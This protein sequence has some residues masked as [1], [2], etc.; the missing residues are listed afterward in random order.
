[1]RST[2]TPRIGE[3]LLALV[4]EA[5]HHDIPALNQLES[6]IKEKVYAL[7]IPDKVFDHFSIC[8]GRQ[9]M[10]RRFV[11]F[12]AGYTEQTRRLAKVRH[13]ALF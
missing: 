12:P 11:P 6:Q 3:R 1:M 8:T 4:G 7:F 13:P 9:A 10:R 2:D 5:S